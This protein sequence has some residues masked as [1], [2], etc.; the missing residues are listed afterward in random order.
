MR[1]IQK[2]VDIIISQVNRKYSIH[3]TLLKKLNQFKRQHI[4][5]LKNNGY[6]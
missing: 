1:Y 4:T 5:H 6:H 3:L 2:L